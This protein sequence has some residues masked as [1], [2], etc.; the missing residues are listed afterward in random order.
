MARISIALE[1]VLKTIHICVT[2]I[3]VAMKINS[4]AYKLKT[5]AAEEII[6]ARGAWRRCHGWRQHLYLGIE[7]CAKK[8]VVTYTDTTSGTPA[9]GPKSRWSAVIKPRR[10]RGPPPDR[11]GE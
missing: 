10:A 9:S 4:D 6:V 2:T 3:I 11:R 7:V 5:I 1:L 8:A